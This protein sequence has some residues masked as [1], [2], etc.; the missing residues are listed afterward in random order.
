MNLRGAWVVAE[1]RSTLSIGGRLLLDKKSTFSILVVLAFIGAV[2][3]G[4]AI[5]LVMP[6]ISLMQGVE[7]D[8]FLSSGL[9]PIPRDVQVTTMASVVAFIFLFKNLLT[10]LRTRWS[11]KFINGLWER[12]VGGIVDNVL[13]SG[14]EDD[15]ES[16][17][18]EYI[19]AALG[20]SRE[21]VAGLL[22]LMQL[23]VS[24]FTLLSI[25]TV[26]WLSSWL[27]TLVV[28]FVMLGLFFFVIRP[29]TRLSHAAGAVQVRA[30]NDATTSLVEIIGGIRYVKSYCLEGD[31]ATRMSRPLREL[32]KA[33]T[34]ARWMAF[35][36][37]PII[38]TVLVLGF[39][40]VVILLSMNS[41]EP[42][43]AVLP[44]LGVYAAATFRLYPVLTGMGS[45]WV[46]VINKK[47]SAQRI[48][49][50]MKPRAR[51][52]GGRKRFGSLSDG[53]LFREVGYVY[54]GRPSALADFTAE[55]KRGQRS[56]LV[57]E[58][59]SGK[60]TAVSLLLGFL[61]PS[62]GAILVDG[63]PLEDYQRESWR[64]R[65][66]YVGQEGFI[67]H[68]TLKEN[69]TLGRDNGKDGHLEEAIRVAGL[70]DFVRTLPEGYGTVLGERGVNVSGGQRQRVSLAR[71]IYSRPEILILDEAMNALD[72]QTA[73]NV[74]RALREYLP[75]STWLLVGHRLS[76]TENF[77][78]ILV[79]KEG[80][81]VGKG[82]HRELMAQRDYYYQLH[83]K[84]KGG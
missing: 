45:Q 9:L 32:K 26:L 2:L 35:I 54:A 27:V 56:A 8:T 14:L 83:L 46:G 13:F 19:A 78:Q 16:H 28:T 63:V 52:P 80:R 10:F 51:E 47:A 36:V 41:M 61:R 58:S 20:E 40:S 77:D 71:A 73:L 84:E 60:S 57:G 48:L 34:T 17:S 50:F 43:R 21:C 29:M 53:I 30:L 62:R 76:D 42:N 25:Y 12:W 64:K 81:L 5:A 1:L 18:G 74:M 66:G 33:M 44:L 55:L 39:C 3:D 72:N 11:V 65:I 68:T 70:E 6:L 49:Q 22:N 24:G 4:L 59:G 37:H 7:L 79:L 31:F 69:I 23:L 15:G 75:E 38:E 67:F 82:S